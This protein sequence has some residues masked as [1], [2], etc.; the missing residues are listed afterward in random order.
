MAQQPVNVTTTATLIHQSSPT[1]NETIRLHVDDTSPVIF[2]G[3]NASVSTSNGLAVGGG[4]N[5]VL[6][7]NN[8]IP[9]NTTGNIIYGIV[10]AGS[11]TVKVSATTA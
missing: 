6:E 3:P 11:G 2:L 4:S 7:R 10:A 9:G 8:T 1:S 5:L